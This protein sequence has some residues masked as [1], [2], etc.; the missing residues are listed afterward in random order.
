[1]TDVGISASRLVELLERLDALE[2]ENKVLRE[3]N[4]LLRRWRFGKSSER[5]SAGQLCFFEAELRSIEVEESQVEQ[6]TAQRTRKCKPG[7]GRTSFPEHLQRV[8]FPLDVPEDERI[9]SCCGG[10][11]QLI[12]E[13]VTERGHIKPAEMIVHQYRRKKYACPHGHQVKSAPLPDGVVDSG[14]YEASVYAHI[15]VSKYGDHLPLNRMEGIFQRHGIKIAKQTMWDMLK[16]IDELVSQPILKQMRAELL[17][18]EILQADETSVTLRLEGQKGTKDGWVW[19]WRSLAGDGHAKVLVEFHQTRGSA[20]PTAFLADWTGIL[21]LD[22]YSGYVPICR[23]NGIVRAGCWAHARRYI[24]QAFDLGSKGTEELLLLMGRLFALERAIKGRA[25][26][27][28]MTHEELLELRRQ[29]RNRSSGRLVERIHE[30]AARLVE[31]RSIL[32]KSKLGKGLTYLANQREALRVFL[33]DPRV[34]VHNNDE[35]RDLR[36]IVTGRK[37]WLVF[38]SQ[39]GGEVACRLYSLILSCIQCGANPEAYIEDVLMAV[40]TTP[41]SQIA[42]LTPWAWVEAQQRAL[43]AI[44]G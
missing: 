34:P 24:K 32:P 41:M 43:V 40:A 36:H 9:C 35:E 5:L 4:A 1:M 20:A 7:H 21:I 17:R 8:E 33:D 14:K 42:S 27:Q 19:G 11:L 44:D 23:A 38:A 31:K 22:G 39:R 13:D 30:A 25:E 2:Q 26:R 12:G 29:V 3:E 16:T 37:N 28:E 6:P 15:A 18:E 10:P